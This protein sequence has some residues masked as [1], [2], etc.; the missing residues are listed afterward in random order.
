M[1]DPTRVRTVFSLPGAAYAASVDWYRV[2]GGTVR[3]LRH[4]TAHET[5]CS[6]G[7]AGT[8]LG[9]PQDMIWDRIIVI[10]GFAPLSQILSC[11]L[12][13]RAQ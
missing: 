10:N 4:V 9:K 2:G 1:G 6:R 7:A 3:G 12:P 13:N 8:R 5:V 11:G